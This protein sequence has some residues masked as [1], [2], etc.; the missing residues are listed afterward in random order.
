M[1]GRNRIYRL[2]REEGLSVRRRKARRRAAER[3]RRSSLSHA[4]MP[5][6]AWT[7]CTISLRTGGS[8]GS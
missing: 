2:Y 4:P 6:G 1:S 3:V 5:V 8:S 7:S